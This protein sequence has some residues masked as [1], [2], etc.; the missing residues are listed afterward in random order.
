LGI[1][2]HLK[3]ETIEIY[4]ES[5]LSAMVYIGKQVTERLEVTQQFL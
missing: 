5:D 1:P 3:K 2:K 4:S